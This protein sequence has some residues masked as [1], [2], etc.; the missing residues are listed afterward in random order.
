MPLVSVK[1]LDLTLSSV[2]RSPIIHST[3]PFQRSSVLLLSSSFKKR[4]LYTSQVG[5]TKQQSILNLAFWQCKKTW[6]RASINTLRCLFGCSIGDFGALW[7]LQGGNFDL[8]MGYMM[9]IPSEQS[10]RMVESSRRL[11]FLCLFLFLVASG[12]MT[13]IILETVLLRFGRDKMA[14]VSALQTALGMSLIS[15]LTMEAVETSV[16]I[17]LTKGIINMNETRF[18]IAAS[19]AALAGYITPLPYNYFRI[20]R[21]GLSCH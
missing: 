11:I 15:M 4:C 10:Q 17:Y 9:A 6:Q 7:I 5:P 1:G 3:A 18:W 21:Y 14:T 12:I 8:S 13:S 2:I 20:K 19:I 16:N